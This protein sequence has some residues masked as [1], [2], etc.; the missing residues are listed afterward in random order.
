MEVNDRLLTRWISTGLVVALL[1]PT[2]ALAADDKR[3]DP[4]AEPSQI[5]QVTS[6]APAAASNS[7]AAADSQTGQTSTDQLPDSPGAVRSKAQASEAPANDQAPA[8]TTAAQSTPQQPS[9]P[10]P[11]PANPQQPVGTAA[12]QAQ[13]STGDAAFTPAGAAIAP[14]KQKRTRTILLKVGALV[15][16]GV[17]LGS[18]AALSSASP[19]RPPGSH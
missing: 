18:V 5:S 16:A 4:P 2:T 17:A 12:A 3:G 7:T 11:S 13:S 10:Q 15:G 9:S 8:P 1:T 19:S 6:P 14:A